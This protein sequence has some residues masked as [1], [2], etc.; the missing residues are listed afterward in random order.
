MCQLRY[1][2]GYFELEMGCLLPDATD[3]DVRPRS[4]SKPSRRP[5]ILTSMLRFCS[6][7]REGEG[8]EVERPESS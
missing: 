5:N 4:L 7:P 6:S 8:R 3:I 2:R 1:E